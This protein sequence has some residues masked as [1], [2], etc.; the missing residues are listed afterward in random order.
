MQK[1]TKAIYSQMLLT[2]EWDSKRKKILKRDGFKCRECGRSNVELHVHHLKY[3]EKTAWDVPDDWLITLCDE[4]HKQ[5]HYFRNGMELQLIDTLSENNFLSV[6]I[7]MII[8]SINEKQL[9][10]KSS[11]NG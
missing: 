6:D 1:I 10:P 4:H 5:E 9:L 8:R 7:F 3:G 11:K 2:P